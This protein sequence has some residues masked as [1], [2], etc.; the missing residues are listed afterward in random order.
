MTIE[1]KICKSVRSIAYP[2][3]LMS[4]FND[5]TF[6]LAKKAN[7]ELGFSFYGGYMNCYVDNW[8]RYD[9]KRIPP[10]SPISNHYTGPVSLVA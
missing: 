7:Y 9:I 2:F 5:Y 10:P 1:T 6:E 4:T 3:G 8:N